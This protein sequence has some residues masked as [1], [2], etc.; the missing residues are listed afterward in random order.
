MTKYKLAEHQI[1]ALEIM[2]SNSNCGIFYD[3]GTGKTMI[4]LTWIYRALQDGRIQTAL[5]VCP[6]SLVPNWEDNV[7]KMLMF[8][9]FTEEGVERL[10]KSLTFTSY[11][12]MYKTEKI[13]VG[14]RDGQTTY[15]K[16]ISL[17][18]E[19]DRIWGVIMVDESHN[20]GTHSSV[21]TKAALTLARLSK[22]RYI[23]SG[24]P[25][26][27]GK[28]IENFSKLYG[29]LKFLEPDIWKNWTQFCNRYVTAYDRWHNPI[30]YDIPSC[31][32]L[33]YNHAIVCRLEDC[34]DMPDL[35]ETMIPCPLAEKKVYKD[36]L[37][38]NYE[39]YNIDL[40][41]AG[42]KYTKMLQVCSGSM[43]RTPEEGG[44]MTFRS[45]KDDVLLDLINSTSDKVV[46][47]C[48]YHASVNRCAEICSKSGR[49]TVIFD[50]HSKGPTWKEFQNGDA[51]AIVC[52]FASG[53][54]G[55]DLFASSHLVMFEPCRSARLLKQAKKRI[56]RK[57]QTKNCDIYFLYTPSTL[58][59]KTWDT[60]RAGADVTDEMLDD[61][62]HGLNL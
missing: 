14:H 31:R 50:G 9:G 17:R 4:A 10:R 47:F 16:S 13:A 57:G 37:D 6:A 60:V 12:K 40:E 15:K 33:M 11:Q 46:I 45:S 5:V 51:T 24:T 52:Q 35:T 19:V 30:S 22:Y 39:P 7:Q 56:Y 29:Q 38:S 23:F 36:L 55:L 26:D 43:K 21:Q 48:N 49:K 3:M 62:A 32:A 59:V 1:Y 25:C 27:G 8:E 44:P 53:G 41:M 42:T 20:L 61:W 18:P 28:G 34:F 54:E 2:D 58:E